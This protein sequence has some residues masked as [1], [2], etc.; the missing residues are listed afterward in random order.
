MVCINLCTHS[1]YGDNRS[2]FVSI[3]SYENQLN[4]ERLNFKL[5]RTHCHEQQI[6]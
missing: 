3:G 6:I 4:M 2:L 5:F 1:E